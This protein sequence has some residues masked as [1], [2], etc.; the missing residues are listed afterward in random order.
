MTSIHALLVEDDERLAKFTAEY[1]TEHG[2]GVSHVRDG[3]VALGELRRRNFDVVVLDVM[4]PGRDGFSVCRGIRELSDVPVLMV[5]ARGEESDRVLGLELGADDYI[6]KPFSPRELLARIHA[7][8]RRS[9]GAL[10]PRS[11]ELRAGPLVIDT[12]SLS[13]SLNGRSLTLSPTEFQLLVRFVERPG[14]VFTREQLLELVKGSAEDAFDRAVD[15]QVSRLRSKLGRDPDG[16]D[17]IKT[18]R[19]VG[20]M[21]VVKQG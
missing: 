18:V 21:L 17:L 1:L 7:F 3:S 6:V 2:L 16:H 10:I 20:Y 19:G 4:L 5:T 15:V 14:R 12:A 13:V 9:R 11:I 8:V